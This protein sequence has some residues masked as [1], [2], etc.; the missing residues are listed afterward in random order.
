MSSIIHSLTAK[1][2]TQFASNQVTWLIETVRD[3]LWSG[4]HSGSFAHAWV[5]ASVSICA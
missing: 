1:W 3:V 4:R 2:T 5:R